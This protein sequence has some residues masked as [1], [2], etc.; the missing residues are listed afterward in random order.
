MFWLKN[1]DL[2]LTKISYRVK[3]FSTLFL[4]ISTDLNYKEK[5]QSR[6]R[7]DSNECVFFKE[8]GH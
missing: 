3:E 4:F 2:S 5:Y 1:L 6:I 7:F 8:K